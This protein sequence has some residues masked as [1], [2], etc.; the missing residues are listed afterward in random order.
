MPLFYA[1][2]ELEG[3]I[4]KYIELKLEELEGSIRKCNELKLEESLKIGY[5]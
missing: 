4:R 5:Y 2:E 3:S 1:G